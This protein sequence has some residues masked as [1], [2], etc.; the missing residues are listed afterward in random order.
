MQ[1]AVMN[2]NPSMR[3]A[4]PNELDQVRIERALKARRRYRYVS[5][6]VHAVGAGY[7]IESPCCS[8]NIDRDGGMIDIALLLFDDDRGEWRL[9]SKD[10]KRGSWE[11]QGC[12]PRLNELLA[13]L[14]A[15]PERRFWQ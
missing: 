13:S 12:Y 2:V 14:N 3:R 9:F 11:L 15:D 5:P 4:Q 6:H 1:A 7:R 8:R 10:H